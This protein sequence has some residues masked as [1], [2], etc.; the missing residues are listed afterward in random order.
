M[1]FLRYVIS[2]FMCDWRKDMGSFR[3][4]YLNRAGVIG[5]AEDRMASEHRGYCMFPG[6]SIS[7]SSSKS[8]D[9][10]FIAAVAMHA[11]NPARVVVIPSTWIEQVH[12]AP[13]SSKRARGAAP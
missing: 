11:D 2:F 9:A 6:H 7:V 10:E 3:F 1:P 5:G 8:R 4:M 13:P 12:G